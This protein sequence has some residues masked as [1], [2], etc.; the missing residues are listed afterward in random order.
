MS[1]RSILAFLRKLWRKPARPVCLLTSFNGQWSYL[2]TG[3]GEQGWDGPERRSCEVTVSVRTQHEEQARI[4][5][6]ALASWGRWS[7]I[8][9]RYTPEGGQLDIRFVPARHDCEY[10]L[11]GG[12]L[13]HAY[14]PSSPIGGRVCIREDVPLDKLQAVLAHEIGHAL[15]LPHAPEMGC[16]M[17]PVYQPEIERPTAADVAALGELYLVRPMPSGAMRAQ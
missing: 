9:F 3:W 7:G 4:S 6:A 8:H 5:V 12:Q 10:V 13:G 2:P 14:Y 1:R 11:E 17:S 15:G 16:L